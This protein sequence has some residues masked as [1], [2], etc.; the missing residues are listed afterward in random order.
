MSRIEQIK[1][2]KRLADV[3]ECKMHKER[4]NFLAKMKEVIKLFG[5][6]TRN[7]QGGLATPQKKG[8]ALKEVLAKSKSLKKLCV[9]AD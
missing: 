5:F 3:L 7:F 6:K 1:A 4:A 2:E 9:N 8:I